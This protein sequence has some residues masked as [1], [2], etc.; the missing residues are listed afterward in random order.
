MKIKM[1]DAFGFFLFTFSFYINHIF[2][3]I[4]R[5]NRINFTIKTYLHFIYTYAQMIIIKVCHRNVF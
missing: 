2:E 3:R 4:A 1:N 5:G